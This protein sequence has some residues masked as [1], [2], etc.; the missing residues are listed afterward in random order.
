[1]TDPTHVAD[2]LLSVARVI[3]NRADTVSVLIS[4]NERGVTYTL[5]AAPEEV[6][7]LIGK[8]GRTARIAH[9][10]FPATPGRFASADVGYT[11]LRGVAGDPTRHV[12]SVMVIAIEQVRPSL[13]AHHGLVSS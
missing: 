8:Q 2:L 6:G 1:M 12:Q 4:Q 5:I 9:D 13:H 11:A 10:S 3:V 7:K